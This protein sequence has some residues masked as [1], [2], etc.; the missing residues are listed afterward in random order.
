[1]IMC[2][3]HMEGGMAL[4]TGDT[5]TL[6]GLA[7]FAG[8]IIS[9]RWCANSFYN[10]KVGSITKFGLWVPECTID[11]YPVVVCSPLERFS[12]DYRASFLLLLLATFFF[13]I[14]YEFLFLPLFLSL[15]VRLLLMRHF[16]WLEKLWFCEFGRAQNTLVVLYM[17]DS[18]I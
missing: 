4:M 1:M 14:V 5:C 6:S 13:G 3:G 8:R 18:G 15:S 2:T 12:G 16:G 17:S 10:V 9:Q 11:V 7:E